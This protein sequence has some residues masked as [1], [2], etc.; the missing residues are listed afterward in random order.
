MSELNFAAHIQALT[1]QQ[2]VEYLQ[3]IQASALEA[4]NLV[5]SEEGLLQKALPQVKKVCENM[6]QLPPVGLPTEGFPAQLC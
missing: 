6:F 3:G 1:P 4:F 2:Q 5:Y